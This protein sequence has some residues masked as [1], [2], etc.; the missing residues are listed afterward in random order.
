MATDNSRAVPEDRFTRAQFG[1]PEKGIVFCCFNNGYKI[2]PAAFGI[3][4]R[5][6]QTVPDSVVWLTRD[7]AEAS[8]NLV[9]EA[10]ARGVDASRL[11]FAERMPDHADYLAR[12]R[13]ADLFLD[14][15]N[16]NAH[17]TA[18]D[19]LWAGVPLVTLA[20]RSFPAR[21]AGSLLRA[22]GLPELVTETAERYEALAL[23]LATQPQ[24]LAEVKARLSANRRATPLFDSEG[25]TRDF[26]RLLET[27]QA[28]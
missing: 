28:S 11:V 23:E 21:V 25:F 15:F 4:M 17:A 6:L 20:G 10:Q 1:L 19:V 24:R 22:I 5:L 2:T 12:Y 14:T 3:W 16:Y 26:E 27:L 13:C 9:K 8:A 18:A 7:S